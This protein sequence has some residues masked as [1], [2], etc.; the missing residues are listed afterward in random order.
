MINVFPATIRVI[1]VQVLQNMIVLV[2]IIRST[3]ETQVNKQKNYKN[4]K[5]PFF[6]NKE[7]NLCK[8]AKGYYDDSIAANCHKCDPSCKTCYSSN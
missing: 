6:C 1:D 5:I 4:I 8:C 3:K 2:V 7:E